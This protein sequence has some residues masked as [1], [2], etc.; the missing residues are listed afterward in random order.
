MR[1]TGAAA[2]SWAYRDAG[3]GMHDRQAGDDRHA[4][5]G[6]HEGLNS[7]VVVGG[8]VGSR[9]ESGLLAGMTHDPVPA[10]AG[11]TADPGFPAQILQT[12]SCVAERADERRA[13]RPETGP[14]EAGRGSKLSSADIGQRLVVIDHGQIQLAG[15]QPRD[16]PVQMIVDHG[17]PHVRVQAAETRECRGHERA[18]HGRE[19]A[20]AQPATTALGNL[21]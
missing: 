16:E 2:A 8:E 21:G 14:R 17:Q 6:R 20:E 19:A 7:D 12:K 3:Q 9:T 11:R 13:A 15:L 4:E 1:R 18:Q 5:A 10:A